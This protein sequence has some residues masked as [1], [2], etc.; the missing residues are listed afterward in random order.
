MREARHQKRANAASWPFQPLDSQCIWLDQTGLGKRKINSRWIYEKSSVADGA[1]RY[2]LTCPRSY[3]VG[4][5]F[6][7]F[8]SAVSTRV[9]VRVTTWCWQIGTTLLARE[10]TQG[11]LVLSL[12][13]SEFVFAHGLI[14]QAAAGGIFLGSFVCKFVNDHFSE[15]GSSLICRVYIFW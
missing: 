8:S 15:M 10:E 7:P 4:F 5:F 3:R 13:S 12:S 14:Q 1:Y 2:L 9:F 11:L 6:S